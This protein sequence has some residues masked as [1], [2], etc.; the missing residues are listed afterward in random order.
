[1][2]AYSI[3]RRLV[4]TILAVEF[5]LAA[6][7][8]TI[9]LAYLRQ[10]HLK[11]FDIMLRGRADSVFGAVQDL[12]DEADSVF[13]DTS[14]LDLPR[15]DIYEVREESGALIGRSPN[16][17]GL[18]GV[19]PRAGAPFSQTEVNGRDYRALVLHLTRNID[20]SAKGPG[21]P[22]KI[23]V[24]YAAPLRPVWHA[25]KDEARLLAFGNSLLL[26][27]T[28]LAAALLLRRGMMPLHALANEASGISVHSWKFQA[29]EEAYAARELRPLATALQSAL[30]RLEQSFRQQQVFISDAAH[31]LKTAVSI[32]KS[33]LQLLA[34]KD[35]T[36]TEYRE[37]LTQCL[38]DCGRVEDLVAKMLTLA[39]IEQATPQPPSLGAEATD[40]NACLHQAALQ[41]RPLAELHGVRITVSAAFAFHTQVPAAD[42]STLVSNL[43]ANAI[44][45]SPRGN[46]SE[47]ELA[48]TEQGFRVRDFGEGISREALPY[49]FDRFFR[50]DRSRAR[51]TG[52]A[53]LGLAI[54]KA[55]VER[56][57][58]KISIESWPG[59]GTLLNVELPGMVLQEHAAEMP[60]AQT[61]AV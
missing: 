31:E 56:Y 40:L 30:S 52:G 41:L 4:I 35:R 26:A 34:Y 2:K 27:L 33:S 15:N 39:S 22:H 25:L 32:V 48:V 3:V 24:Y 45:H 43:L 20:P 18:A 58:G 59:E 47:V 29:P 60:R 36:L 16:W 50:E 57:G 19:P 14:V 61:S 11:T 1:M 8:T 23:V 46:D 44:Q 38:N 12:E 37:G 17:N 53:G 7:T 51:N 6:L 5:L 55:I 54:C 9:E 49:V 42:C 21:I 13:L 10:Q 28:A